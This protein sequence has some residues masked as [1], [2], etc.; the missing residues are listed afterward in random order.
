MPRATIDYMNAR[1]ECRAASGGKTYARTRN[2]VD[3]RAQFAELEHH[4][5]C[6]LRAELILAEFRS[7]ASSLV[8]VADI[9]AGAAFDEIPF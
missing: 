1:R 3:D 9:M 8:P 7:W 2:A 5:Q 4:E 6:M